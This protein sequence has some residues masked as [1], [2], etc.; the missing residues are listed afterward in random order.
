[1]TVNDVAMHLKVS[2][3][4]VRKMLRR[5]LDHFRVGNRIRTSVE[6]IDR[7]LNGDRVKVSVRRDTALSHQ[8][9]A[10]RLQEMRPG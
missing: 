3:D 4:T 9:V 5:G 6:A 8:E 7:Y 10:R 1:M 2:D